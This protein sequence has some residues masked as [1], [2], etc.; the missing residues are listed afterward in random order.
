MS[1]SP[2]I[3]LPNFKPSPPVRPED[4]AAAK[5]KTYSYK[6]APAPGTS[7]PTA[8]TGVQPF[9]TQASAS[10]LPLLP[11]SKRPT[12]SSHRHDAN[13]AL[14]IKV[15]QDICTAVDGWHQSLRQILL[16]IQ[17]LYLEGPMVEGW[18]EAVN[19]SAD[20]PK[21]SQPFDPTVLRHADPQDLGGYVDRLCNQVDTT[22]SRPPD[23]PPSSGAYRLCSLDSDGQLQCQPCPA[24]QLLSVSQ[25]IARHQRLRQLLND[26]QYLEAKLK[27]AVESLTQVRSDLGITPD[28][29]EPDVD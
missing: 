29:P 10:K 19:P 2:R 16:D 1:Y 11:R 6:I 8:K 27:R 14:A 12:L 28:Q 3:E 22:A 18:L 13:P 25:A 23:V 20:S 21:V 7:T 5:A 24:D 4:K 15:L 26:K 17:A 9:P